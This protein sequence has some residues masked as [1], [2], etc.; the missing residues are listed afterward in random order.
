M[1][2]KSMV[3]FV[4]LLVFFCFG[5]DDPAPEPK[6]LL[7]WSE[8]TD[9]NDVACICYAGFI[10]VCG[11]GI[12]RL[13]AGLANFDA[14]DQAIMDYKCIIDWDGKATDEEWQS[15]YDHE[16][17]NSRSISVMND[18]NCGGRDTMG[19]YTCQGEIENPEAMKPEL[20][21]LKTVDINESCI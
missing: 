19:V 7:V 17:D 15:A 21:C 11:D 2:K 18:K 10:P 5:C 12:L 16:R 3:V 14:V 9:C 20:Y 1:G 13:C 8:P 4:C 6:D